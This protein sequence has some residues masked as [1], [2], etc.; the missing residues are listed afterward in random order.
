[1]FRRLATLCVIALS[2]SACDKVKN[3]Q[4]PLGGNSGST[5]GG[6][7]GDASSTPTST[8]DSYK[9]AIASQD[10]SKLYGLLSVEFQKQAEA[11]VTQLKQ[12]LAS[13]DEGKKKAAEEKIRARGLT[14]EQFAKEVAPKLAQAWVG[15]E[16]MKGSGR[17]PREIKETKAI[18]VDDAKAS[19]TYLSP[20]GKEGVIRFV[21][22]SGAWK[23][24]P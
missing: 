11:E 22:Q 20:E 14:P 17:L 9:A 24:A 16:A 2:L 5:G 18:K 4:N 15:A 1:M 10:W 8:L 13:G 6:G 19:V 7:A 12:D 3:I 21:K 23:F